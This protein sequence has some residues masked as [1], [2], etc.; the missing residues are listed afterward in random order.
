MGNNDF[1]AALKQA[2]QLH[3]EVENAY[4]AHTATQHDANWLEKRRLLLAD[5]AIHLL[6]TALKAGELNQQ[7]LTNNL[8]AILT[9]CDDFLPEKG[10]K[11]AADKLYK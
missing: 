7:T 6:D 11:N 1:S 10:L 3:G 2:W 5:I 9:I 4:L 8:D